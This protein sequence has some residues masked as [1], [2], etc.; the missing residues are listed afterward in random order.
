MSERAIH[1]LEESRQDLLTGK[2]FYEKLTAPSEPAV[3]ATVGSPMSPAVLRQI[4]SVA[5]FR[6]YRFYLTGLQQPRALLFGC[7]GCA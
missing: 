7:F 2:A 1:F 3:Q 4:I 5:I 6:Q